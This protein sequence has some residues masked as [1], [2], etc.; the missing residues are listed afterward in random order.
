MSKKNKNIIIN[1]YLKKFLIILY[2]III[3]FFILIFILYLSSQNELIKEIFNFEKYYLICNQE[4]ILKK[5]I[6][7]NKKRYF[8]NCLKP[9]ISIISSI[10][11][12]EKYILRFLRSIQ[13]QNYEDVEI[14]L[15]D[16][17]SKDNSIFYLEKFQK[18]DERI[19]IIKH[20]KNKGTLISRNEGI[21][22]SKG[23]YILI[24]D[25][26][27]IFSM[28]ILNQNIIKIKKTKSDFI[29]FNT[30]LGNQKVLIDNQI[31]KYIEKTIY[32]P[33][34]SSFI[35][36]D[37]SQKGIIDPIIRNKLFKRIILIKALN[38]INEYFLKQNMIFYEDTLLNFMIY[39]TSKSLFFLK[40]IGYFYVSN[41]KSIT[42]TYLRDQ[43]D[44][45]RF[46]HSF[47]IFLKFILYYTKNNKYEKNIINSILLKEMKILLSDS[48]FYKLNN[49]NLNNFYIDVINLYVK[50]KFISLYIKNKFI[51]IKKSLLI[52]K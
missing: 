21:F 27:D 39:K 20:T 38:L 34:L 11:N 28:D 51:N 26:D 15:I 37:I 50:N 22:L 6:I 8:K 49:S 52:K 1:K 24:P 45:N 12:K 9:K 4:I 40:N 7:I 33:E 41:K 42:K 18:E 25:I 31:K 29:I 10:Y 32:Q 3:F 16:D 2:I 30:Y 23:K 46:F 44:L 5:Q 13:N 43:N 19:K 35:F 47:F 48:I 36:Y 14:I 17:F